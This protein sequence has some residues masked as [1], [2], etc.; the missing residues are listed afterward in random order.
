MAHV[1]LLRGVNVGGY[2]N[3]RPAALA[4]QLRHL[5]AINIGAAGTFV[6]RQPISRSKLREEFTRRLPFEAD[7]VICR[8]RDITALIASD[9]FAKYPTRPGIVRFVSVL[10]G[11]P[12]SEPALPMTFPPRGRWLLKI[13]SREDR[14]VFG[15]YRRHMKV[16]GYLGALDRVFGVR[17]TT[18]NWNTIA[19]I[20][21]VLRLEA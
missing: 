4:E 8:S 15:V 16:I 13:L 1:V 20:A 17:V 6:I 21:E 14:F 12:R 19:A 11:R 9:V 2:R 3:F 10:T 18:R 5:D 7:V